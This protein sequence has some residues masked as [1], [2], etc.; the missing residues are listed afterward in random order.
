MVLFEILNINIYK[1]WTSLDLK[2]VDEYNRREQEIKQMEKELE[3]KSNALNAYRQN[4][5]EASD[6]LDSQKLS[7]LSFVV[8]QNCSW[9]VMMCIFGLFFFCVIG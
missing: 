5:S 4:I 9:G 8:W 2:V 1:Y 7:S 6:Y 3:E